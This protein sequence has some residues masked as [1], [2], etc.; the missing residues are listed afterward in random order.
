MVKDVTEFLVDAEMPR[1][2]VALLLEHFSRLEDEPRRDCR[3]LQLLRDWSH[4][5]AS[6]TEILP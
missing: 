3:R 1:A 2:R 5:E 6:I 4:D